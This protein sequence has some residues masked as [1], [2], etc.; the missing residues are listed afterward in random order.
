[1]ET[2]GEW[3]EGEV[4]R[5]VEE[6]GKK[7]AGVDV[8]VVGGPRNVIVKHGK[9]HERAFCPER[10]VN[11]GRDEEGE[12]RGVSVKYHLT[13]PTPFRC[14]KGRTWWQRLGSW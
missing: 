4:R 14:G 5:V 2:K 9:R 7:G 10:T 3:N 11:V 12:L 1:V 6:V 8:V 13:E